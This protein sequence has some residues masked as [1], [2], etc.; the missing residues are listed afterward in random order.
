LKS[1]WFPKLGGYGYLAAYASQHSVIDTM[2]CSSQEQNTSMKK[3]KKRPNIRQMGT[4][5]PAFA[6]PRSKTHL[7][8]GKKIDQASS[9]GI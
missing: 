2:F 6:S 8:K 9:R 4:A 1:S 7:K 3:D 5:I